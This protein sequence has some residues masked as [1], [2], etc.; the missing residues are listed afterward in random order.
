MEM[1]GFPLCQHPLTG[2]INMECVLKK[3]EELTVAELYAVLQLRNRVFAVE[4]NC[5]YADMDDKDQD[6]HHLMGWEN[7]Q[8][9]AYTRLIPPGLIYPQASIGRVVTA[10]DKRKTGAGKK[11]MELSIQYLYELFGKG[12]IR[13]S[14]Q[15]YLIRFYRSFGFIE[16][17]EPYLED[18][19]D[20][21]EMLLG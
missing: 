1:K 3:F 19:I 7:G 20:H 21:I 9:I 16:R 6:S 11:I 2:S 17:G 10:T 14:A 4:Q 18:H 8:L 15:V 12:V 13:I 5:V